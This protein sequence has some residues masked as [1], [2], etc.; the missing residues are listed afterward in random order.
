MSTDM[1]KAINFSPPTYTW[2][3]ASHN[4]VCM[5]FTSYTIQICRK[6]FVWSQ[7]IIKSLWC[8]KSKPSGVFRYCSVEAHNLIKEI[9]HGRK[10]HFSTKNRL[11]SRLGSKFFA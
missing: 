5:Q 10:I 11:P 9:D 7:A 8:F 3:Y 6:I 2:G 1:R 4:A